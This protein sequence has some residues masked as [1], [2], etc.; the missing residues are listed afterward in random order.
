MRR[1]RLPCSGHPCLLV[2]RRWFGAFFRHMHGGRLDGGAGCPARGNSK[3]DG[4]RRVI[5]VG[6]PLRV[7]SRGDGV[8]RSGGRDEGVVD[9]V[10]L[11]DVAGPPQGGMHLGA[12]YAAVLVVVGAD[13]SARLQLVHEVAEPDFAARLIPVDGVVEVATDDSQI[14]GPR[15]EFGI[16]QMSAAVIAVRY[17]NTMWVDRGAVALLRGR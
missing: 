1:S 9:V 17:Q 4:H 2:R 12:R 7:R 11:V 3:I 16:A 10:G 8:N 5:A 6:E 15:E 14:R 13:Q